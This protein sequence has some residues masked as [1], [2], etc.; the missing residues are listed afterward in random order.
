MAK[1][2]KWLKDDVANLPPHKIKQLIDYE[3]WIIE[4]KTD[5]NLI[6]LAKT[7]R[8]IYQNELNIRQLFAQQK[9][10]QNEQTT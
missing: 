4:T 2:W 10:A 8:A 6:E 7:K 5:S 3:N 1:I 9:E